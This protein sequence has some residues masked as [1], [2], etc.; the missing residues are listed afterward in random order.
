MEKYQI[1]I[2]NI[3]RE[4]KTLQDYFINDNDIVAQ[5]QIKLEK[6]DNKIDLL[7]NE[8][9]NLKS[10]NLYLSNDKDRLQKQIENMEDE[11]RNFTKV[12][13]IIALEN[14][15]LK[16][17]EELKYHQSLLETKSKVIEKEDSLN[18]KTKIINGV[19]YFVDNDK[20]IYDKDEKKLGYLSKDVDGKT[21]VKWL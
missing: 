11:H 14:E 10:M 20:N 18:Y 1:I 13:R 19:E 17:R 3:S 21:R 12:S 16:L 4:I 9:E 7:A 5:M 6:S 2:D 15:N 8:N